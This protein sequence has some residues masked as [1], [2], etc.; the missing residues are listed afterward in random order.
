VI[1]ITSVTSSIEF[2]I[3]FGIVCALAVLLGWP[4]SHGG[5]A[6]YEWL[7]GQTV[8]SGIAHNISSAQEKVDTLKIERSVDEDLSVLSIRSVSSAVGRTLLEMS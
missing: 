4:S 6:G 7:Y 5:V 3:S 1:P 8:T 2:L